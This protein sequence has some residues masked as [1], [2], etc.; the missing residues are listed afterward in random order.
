M[1]FF[2][3]AVLAIA[4]VQ[5][6]P[7]VWEAPLA[8]EALTTMEDPSD[9]VVMEDPSASAT[10]GSTL[11]EIMQE[12]NLSISLRTRR[13]SGCTF[14][15]GTFGGGGGGAFNE[16]IN[17]CAATIRRIRIRHGG[18]IDGIQITYRL[19]NG[20]DYTA[21]HHGGRGGGESVIDVNVNGGEKIIGVFGQ[22]G[23]LVDRLG[24]ITNHGRIFGPYGGCGGGH[25][26]VNSC[27]IRGVYGRSGGR[28][29]SIGFF[30]SRL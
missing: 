30:C 2:L 18:V 24:F 4:A 29:D 23:S 6:K 10:N 27:H 25:F 12:L 16:V 28:I 20:Q 11:E 22:S 13:Q 8:Q 7:Q 14:A 5:T 9:S 17:E 1:L 19:S 15:A 21:G 3:T 26:R